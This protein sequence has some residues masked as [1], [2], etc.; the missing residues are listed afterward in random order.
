MGY[1]MK[2]NAILEI[3]GQIVDVNVYLDNDDI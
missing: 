2:D 3:L 1:V